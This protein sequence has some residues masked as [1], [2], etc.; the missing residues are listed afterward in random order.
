MRES[1]VSMCNAVLACDGVKE[2][3]KAW[4]RDLMLRADPSIKDLFRG[5]GRTS[6]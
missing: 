6:R 1:I 3:T 2:G 5:F 4:A